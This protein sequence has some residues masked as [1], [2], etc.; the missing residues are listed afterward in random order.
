MTQDREFPESTE[1]IFNDATMEDVI[2]GLMDA[3]KFYQQASFD[4]QEKHEG[5]W[6]KHE[7][8]DDV[9]AMTG[10][11][12]STKPKARLIKVLIECLNDIRYVKNE[13][14]GHIMWKHSNL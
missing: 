12:L 6:Q 13:Y 4:K 9:V 2:A 7:V 1:T 14:S 11:Q 10:D 8:W 3:A 5:V